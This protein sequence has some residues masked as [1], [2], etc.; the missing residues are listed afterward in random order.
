MDTLLN[1]F[2]KY[3]QCGSESHNE[4]DFCELIEHELDELGIRHDRQEVGLSLGSNGWNILAKVQGNPDKKPFLFVF[5]LDTVAP[6][7]GIEVA[8]DNGTIQSKGN[9]ILGAD[10]KLAIALVLDAIAN[11]QK[12]EGLNRPVEMLFTVCQEVGLEGSFY[13]DYSHIESE[14]ALVIDHFVLGE[15]LTHTPCRTCFNIEL[16]G[17]SSHVIT[18]YEDSANALK[19]A[20]DIVHQIDLGRISDSL[21][22]NVSDFVSLSKTNII[23]QYARFDLEIRAFNEG[24]MQASIHRVRSLAESVSEKTGCTFKM[25]ETNIIPAADF[26]V[27][28]DVFERLEEIYK[29]SGLTLKRARSFGCLDATCI[30]NIGIKTVPLGINIYNS[31]SVRE[32]IEFEEMQQASKLIKNIILNF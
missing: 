4:R 26:G 1:R 10:G 7:N 32:R 31:H 17:R 24:E 16:F 9:T 27:H 19:A 8:V 13:A 12:A 23:P 25:K 20:V 6:G 11:L 15:A 2:I 29:N 30:N 21:S 28:T 3:V 5:H 22:I 18:G 14:E